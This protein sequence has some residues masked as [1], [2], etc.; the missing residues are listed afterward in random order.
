MN[1]KRI[2][3]DN[4]NVLPEREF[5]SLDEFWHYF[6]T[7]E[8]TYTETNL[9]RVIRGFLSFAN[10]MEEGDL[11]KAEYRQF[12]HKIRMTYVELYRGEDF[13]VALAQFL[14]LFCVDYPEIWVKLET[15][16][17]LG[18]SNNRLFKVDELFL[19]VFANCNSDQLQQPLRGFR[20]T[21]S[22]V[23]SR[24]EQENR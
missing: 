6:S 16:K 17:R 4:I 13:Y 11:K 15:S 8:G 2:I 7:F 22:T 12:L 1:N 18:F 24:S 9:T 21:F 14:D 20:K 5:A 10:E 23:R 3:V 19:L